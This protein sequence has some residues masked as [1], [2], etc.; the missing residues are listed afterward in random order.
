MPNVVVIEDEAGNRAI[1]IARARDVGAG[2]PLD[3]ALAA[4]QVNGRTPNG[5]DSD[6]DDH[7]DNPFPDLL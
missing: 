7:D 3:A 5:A 4:K 1:Q 2:A 6:E